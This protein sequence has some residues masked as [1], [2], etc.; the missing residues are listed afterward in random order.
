MTSV[1]TTRLDGVTRAQY[2]SLRA[3]VAWE[4]QAPAGLRVHVASFD[5]HDVLCIVEVWDSVEQR[6]AFARDR[7]N[8]A[9]G[10]V[11]MAMQPQRTTDEAHHFFVPAP[12]PRRAGN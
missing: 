8:P 10:Q 7:V 3:L 6:D 1:I 4:R 5:E 2:D 9:L 11:G 12:V